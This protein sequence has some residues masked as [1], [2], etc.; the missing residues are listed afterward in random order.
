MAIRNIQISGYRSIRD[1]HLNLTNLN[2]FVGPNGCGK[3]NLFR[4]MVL[5]ASA[6]RG[7][8][9]RTMAEAASDGYRVSD[10]ICAR[11][12][13]DNGALVRL[14]LFVMRRRHV[15]SRRNGP[16]FNGPAA[17]NGFWIE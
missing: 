9:A 1:L 13:G 3:S 6:A 15:S 8:F 14:R 2:V 7:N 5:L 4:A 17:M 10:A 16:P 11:L 12:D